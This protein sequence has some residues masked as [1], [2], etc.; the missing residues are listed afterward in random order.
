MIKRLLSS[1]LY[2]LALQRSYQIRRLYSNPIKLQE[3]NL[4]YIL[5]RSKNT[6]FGR[7]FGFSEIKSIED[8]QKMAPL[9]HYAD[10]K[11]W[12]EALLKGKANH[13]WPGKTEYFALTS[14]TTSGSSKYIPMSQDMIR[15]NRKAGLDCIF[16]YLLHTKDRSLFDGK[17]L[18]LGGSTSLE[19]LEGGLLAGDMSGVMSKFI[20][21]YARGLYEPGRDIALIS[22]WEEKIKAAVERTKDKDV[23]LVC[24]IPSWLL[25]IFDHLLNAKK[26]SEIC[27]IWQ[28]LSL[29]IYGGL[30]FTPYEKLMQDLIG[31]D[32][33]YMETYFSSEALIGIQDIPS[34]GKSDEGLLLMLDYGVFYE[35]VRPEDLERDN[36][37]RY[38]VSD[39]E[40]DVNYA[41]VI[42]NVNGLHSYIIGD[43]VRF[44]S[45]NPLRIRVTGRIGHYLSALGEH[46]IREDVEDA[47]NRASEETGALVTD[48]TVAPYY[49]KERAH[50]PGHQWLI[51]FSEPP[52]DLDRFTQIIDEALCLRSDDYMVHREKDFSMS[53]PLIRALKKGT[54][55]KWHKK[56]GTLGGQHKT[57]RLSNDR[58]MADELI[59]LDSL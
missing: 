17:L 40:T 24:G 19:K 31:K 49:A 38:T 50:R 39:V 43:T 23:R 5:N 35:F 27:E 21:F 29:L 54:F 55:Y 4:K 51:E 53:P 34:R 3:R 1:I 18:F 44:V 32:I 41:I 16:F 47:L 11:P 52:R 57:P 9:M 7:N 36:P 22:N 8:Y 14:G 30:D 26:K 33:Y 12:I 59:E 6:A 45:K 20:P 48:Y 13:I 28:N 37:K 58:T 15:N 56:K 10:M 2:L 25:V 42:T 46:L